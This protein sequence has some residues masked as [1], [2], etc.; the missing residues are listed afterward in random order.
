[1]QLA[2][3]PVFS[4][5]STSLYGLTTIRAF[6]AEKDF[7]KQFDAAQDVHSAAW[8]LF[9]ATAR[10]L[11]VCIDWVSVVYIG[12][13]TFSFMFM[14]QDGAAVGL[15]VSSALSL[16]GLFQWGVRQSAEAEK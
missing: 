6:G 13:V 5:L 14:E 2:R 7:E 1:M 12:I 4:Q 8:Y 15:A 9:L 10:W 11:G 3:S 16:T